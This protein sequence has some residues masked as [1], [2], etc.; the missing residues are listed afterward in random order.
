MEKMQPG[1]NLYFVQTNNGNMLI[2]QSQ[3]GDRIMQPIETPQED[4]G[5]NTLILMY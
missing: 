2:G 3:V 5:Q 1:M 4:N